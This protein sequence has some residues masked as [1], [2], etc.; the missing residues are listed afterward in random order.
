MTQWGHTPFTD[1]VKRL[2]SMKTSEFHFLSRLKALLGALSV[3]IG[4]RSR[5]PFVRSWSRA[6]A[7]DRDR[8]LLSATHLW[9][10][11]I[12][13]SLLPKH[14]CRHHPHLANR[15]ADCWGDKERLQALI[16]DLLIDR[17]GDRKGFSPRV[18]GEIEQLELLHSRWLDDPAAARQSMVARRRT[19]R[20]HGV[21]AARDADGPRRAGLPVKPVERPQPSL[22]SLPGA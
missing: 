3:D 10:R 18:R 5:R 21:H 9:L 1:A 11:Q 8:V 22:A 16:D 2:A 14:M 6:P 17:R 20:V 13:S 7:R 4:G 19:V 15:F 12:P